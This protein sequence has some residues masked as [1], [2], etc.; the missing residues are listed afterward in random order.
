MFRGCEKDRAMRMRVAV[1]S[2]RENDGGLETILFES[3][4]TGTNFNVNAY[5]PQ[6]GSQRL[7]RLP[8][9]VPCV[10]ASLST[11]DNSY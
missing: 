2:R 7:T 6:T 5:F 9:Q 3:S 11:C 10:P 4:A 8:R 1:S